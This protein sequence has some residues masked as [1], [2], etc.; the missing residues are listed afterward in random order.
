MAKAATTLGA[1]VY[2]LS[3]AGYLLGIDGRVL[4]RWAQPAPKGEPPLLVPSH[5]WAYSFYDL[6]SLEVISIF[7]KRGIRRVGARRAI[8]Y[9]QTEY[10]TDHPLADQRV[11]NALATADAHLMWKETVDLTKSGQLTLIK[12]LRSHLVP[13][14]YGSDLLARFWRPA[15]SVVLDPEIQA[16]KPCIDKTR[17]TTDVVADRVAQGE[18]V[19]VVAEDLRLTILQVSRAVAFEDHLEAGQGMARLVA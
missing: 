15:L 11:V 3:E 2:G 19:S 10:G 6:V 9:L 8:Q 13:I 5:G 14:E 16:G 7:F 1:G 4:L 17:V 18:T 12:T